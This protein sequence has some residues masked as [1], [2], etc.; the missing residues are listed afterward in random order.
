M[1]RNPLRGVSYI[2][3]PDPDLEY[4]RLRSC[5]RERGRGVTTIQNDNVYVLFQKAKSKVPLLGLYLV[6]VFQVK[7][8][9]P[10]VYTKV[11][12]S[13]MEHW[14]ED[15]SKV[16]V[17][18]VPIVMRSKTL[19]L[20]WSRKFLHHSFFFSYRR[21]YPS[22]QNIH[23]M[24][25][26]GRDSFIRIKESRRQYNMLSGP[27]IG[28]ITTDNPWGVSVGTSP[29]FEGGSSKGGSPYLVTRWRDKRSGKSSLLVHDTSL[30]LVISKLAMGRENFNSNSLKS[31]R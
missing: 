17:Y 25:T 27:I 4:R 2:S 26:G 7:E 22:S 20:T 9:Y 6:K 31:L 18:L 10:S 23:S 13:L 5:S 15:L 8:S 3:S 29:D 1:S 30:S 28:S 11:S 21:V 16:K 19:T 24:V 14:K 12:S